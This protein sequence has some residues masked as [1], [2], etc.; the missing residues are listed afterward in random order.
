VQF[1]QKRN[2]DIAAFNTKTSK[3]FA[4][5][6][7]VLANRENISLDALRPEAEAFYER[8]C[9]KYFLTC[10][11][12]LR[13]FAPGRLYLGARMNVSNPISVRSAARGCDVLSF[14]LYQSDV[15]NFRPGDQD[16][17]VLVSEFHFGSLDRGY[18]S[19]GL[20]PASDSQDRAD[21]YTFY[22]HGALKNPYIIGAHWFAYCPQAITGRGD[23][24]NG[25]T[26][27]FDICN[28]PYPDLR[29]ALRDVGYRMYAIRSAK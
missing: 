12:A 8:Y 19:T 23:N 17:P 21:K 24:E 25:E 15:N 26:G 29:Q 11:A 20:Q 3:S 16:K 4:D 2:P 27:L 18:F 6:D 1:L 14:N 5:W 13:E 28:S 10:R 7:A 22:V 9:D